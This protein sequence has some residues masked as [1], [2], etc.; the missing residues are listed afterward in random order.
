MSTAHFLSLLEAFKIFQLSF[1]FV[2]GKFLSFC[3]QSYLYLCTQLSI[4]FL[5]SLLANTTLIL[6]STVLCLLFILYNFM[7]LTPARFY[8]LTCA[9]GESQSG[10]HIEKWEFRDT[11][12]CRCSAYL[13][14]LYFADLSSRTR[15]L[16]HRMIIPQVIINTMLSPFK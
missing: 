12:Q 13:L 4:T 6:F 9:A 3:D 14:Q 15:G 7:T 11:S 2:E 16:S 5:C 10:L 8:I 1:G